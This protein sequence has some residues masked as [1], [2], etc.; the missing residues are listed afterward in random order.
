MYF[1]YFYPL[2]LDRDVNRTPVVTRLLTAVMLVVFLWAQ[3]RENLFSVW[4][5]DLAFYPGGG[6]PWTA[7]TAIF[8]HGGWLHLAG[9]LIYLNVF[10]PPLEDRLG[11]GLFLAVFLIMGTAG[12]LVH[13]I[14]S[15]WGL[16]GRHGVGVMGAS[17][18][19]AGLLALS[20][21]RLYRARVRVGYWVF[22]PLMGQNRAG[23]AHLPVL[24]GAGL[25]LVLQVVHA[26][27]AGETGAGVSYGAHLGGF[28]S[29]L[30]LGLGL[31]LL[32]AARRENCQIAA[33]EYF[34]TGQ[35]YAAAGAWTEYLGFNPEDLEGQLGRARCRRLLDQPHQALRDYRSVLGRLQVERQVDQL[36]DVFAE[37]R[38]AELTRHLPADLLTAVAAWME[39]KMD[40][41]GALAVY[42]DL[43]E[44]Y[45]ESSSG[46]RAL[47]RLVHL[48][49]GKLADEQ[50]AAR[51]LAIACRK[52]PGGSWREYLAREFNA[53]TG[54]GAGDR[55][56]H[57]EPLPT[58]TP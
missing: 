47:V 48:Y 42:R 50:E 27:V 49:H 11:S 56:G 43:Y 4:P 33:R 54:P 35:F 2:G 20:L 25:W 52:L 5:W 58:A 10:G 15:A 39:K 16:I 1:F 23:Q 44:S 57:R 24:A 55:E 13:A 38:R 40:Y 8:L 19:L 45:P 22:A 41:E 46:Q 37:C 34:A 29:G 26:L 9:N 12:N 6:A 28:M 18:A 30:T 31:G 51:W 14:D 3:Y 53:A 21:L 36:L 17:G 7:L 32:K